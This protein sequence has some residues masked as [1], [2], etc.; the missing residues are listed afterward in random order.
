GV[1]PDRVRHRSGVLGELRRTQHAH[2]LDALDGARTRGAVVAR[3]ARDV[4]GRVDEARFSLVRA[5]CVRVGAPGREDVGR[6]LLVAED[7]EAFLQRELEP[8]AA[9]DAV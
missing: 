7:G 2:V 3:A 4:P 1:G 6:E 9:G 8:V 5:W